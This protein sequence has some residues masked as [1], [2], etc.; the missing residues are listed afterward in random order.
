MENFNRA[1]ES[2]KIINEFLEIKNMIFVIKN[3]FDGYNNRLKTAED[4]IS[5]PNLNVLICF[6]VPT[7]PVFIRNFIVPPP[8]FFKLNPRRFF[9][10]F[11]E[12]HTLILKYLWKWKRP[13]VVKTILK[14]TSNRQENLLWGYSN[15][16]CVILV[17]RHMQWTLD[18]W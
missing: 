15:Y 4:R 18:L 8:N 16:C 7:Q 12:I 6:L 13:W 14:I 2:T 3:S 10:F 9:F 5:G 11:V 1:M 17:Q